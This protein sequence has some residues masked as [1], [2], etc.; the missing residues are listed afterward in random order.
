[1]T[2]EIYHLSHGDTQYIIYMPGSVTECFEF[3]WRS[4]D[5]ADKYQTPVFVISDLDLGMN[6]WMTKKFEYPD[7]PIERGKLIWEEELEKIPD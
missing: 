3:G 2:A 7:R 5:I 6:Q 1:M 4:L